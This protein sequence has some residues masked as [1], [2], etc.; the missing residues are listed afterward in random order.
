ML[1][2]A[3]QKSLTKVERQVYTSGKSTF[4]DVGI[5][6]TVYLRTMND[7]QTALNGLQFGQGFICICD[8]TLDIRFGDRVTIEGATYVVKGVA[9]HDRGSYCDYMRLMLT[10]PQV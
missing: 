7:E 10:K 5:A 1:H 4:T 8:V 9:K 2:I 3:N 6:S